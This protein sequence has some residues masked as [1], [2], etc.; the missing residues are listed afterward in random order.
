MTQKHEHD[1]EFSDFC[2]AHVCVE[3]DDHKGLARCWCGWS[4]TDPGN[5]RQELVDAGETIEPDELIIAHIG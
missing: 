1:Y 3:C 4:V 5:G 2:A